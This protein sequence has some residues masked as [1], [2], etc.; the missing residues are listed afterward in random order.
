M[1]NHVS[2]EHTP[3]GQTVACKRS[4]TGAGAPRIRDEAA[5]LQAIDHPGVVRVIELREDLDGP[6]LVTEY[7]GPRTL[8]T[9]GRL[10]T[11]RTAVLVGDLAATIA[12]L[13]T[14]GQVHG[15]VCPEHVLVAGDRVVLCGFATD[16]EAQPADDVHGIGQCL[17]ALLE[18][19]L[20]EEPIPD[21]RPWR[22]TPWVGYRHRALLT[23]AD[24]ATDDEPARRPAARALADAVR[25]AGGV[26]PEEDDRAAQE[27]PVHLFAQSIGDLLA[28]RLRRR[29]APEPKDRSHRPRRRVALLA[30]VGLVVASVGVLGAISRG[31]RPAEAV[32]VADQVTAVAPCPTAAAEA[33]ADL[34][35]DGCPEAVELGAGWIEVDGQRFRV[36]RPGN[37]LAVGDWDGDGQSTVALLQR[38][39]GRLWTFP[40]WDPAGAVTAEPAGDFP[41]A[42]DLDDRPA[43]GRDQLLVRLRNGAVEPVPAA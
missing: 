21:R 20:D 6:R 30:A 34:D 17:Q 39:S 9:M 40:T 23:L 27:R 25:A 42:V 12:D 15:A 16:G 33:T 18:P 10:T 3:D 43:G 32:P 5:R 26:S 35:G 38:G 2:I 29:P 11:Q 7:V 22:R 4:T 31:R 28:V 13:H 36:G 8:A 24:Q 14:A 1:T 19:D 41:G 37:A